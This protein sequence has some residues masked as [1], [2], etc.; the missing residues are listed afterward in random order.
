MCWM[1]KQEAPEYKRPKE[2]LRAHSEQAT[3]KGKG[4]G[5]GPSRIAAFTG[6]LQALSKREAARWERPTRQGWQ[7]SSKYGTIWNGRGHSTWYTTASWPKFTTLLCAVSSSSSAWQ[8]IENTFVG[9]TRTNR[10]ESSSRSSSKRSFGTGTVSSDR[11]E[12]IKSKFRG[13]VS[14]RLTRQTPC[15]KCGLE[16][17]IL[18]RT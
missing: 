5:L 13:R 9:G 18:C 7:N 15:S 17:K 6:L 2:Q 12:L 11:T 10:S 4:H 1:I 3:S 16:K 14:T 8:S